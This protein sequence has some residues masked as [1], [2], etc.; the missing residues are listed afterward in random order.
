MRNLVLTI[1]FLTTLGTSVQAQKFIAVDNYGRNRMKIYEGD[2]IKF[3]MKGEK[4]VY[5]DEVYALTD[6]SFYLSKTGTEVP[7]SE[8]SEIRR[9][10]VLPRVIF[11]GSVFIGSGF[12]ISSA[13]NRDEETTKAKDIQVFQ[14][15][16]FYG[17]AAAMYP[18]FWK[19]YR[20]GRNSQA[21]ILDVTI[22]KKP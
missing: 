6:S 9:A 19:K 5:T 15:L 7:L 10:R 3:K 4:A 17:L 8:L 21:Q 1:L 2:Q 12:L 20:L 11:G 22:R 16:A 18:F 14:G 13:I